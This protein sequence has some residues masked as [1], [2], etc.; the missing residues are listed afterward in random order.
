MAP[1][2]IT[3]KRAGSKSNIHKTRPTIS[4]IITIVHVHAPKLVS[5]NVANF[6][7][8][9]QEMTGNV[10]SSSTGCIHH[11]STESDFSSKSTTAQNQIE[12]AQSSCAKP[13]NGSPATTAESQD[14]P[15]MSGTSRCQ[16]ARPMQLHPA[17][18]S[19]ARVKEVK[20]EDEKGNVGG[21]L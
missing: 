8:L 2:G 14:R 15:C 4:P 11:E 3:A 5:T 9:V 10:S 20:R 12:I 13:M 21:T 6:R 16:Q 1:A 19:S 7:A 17:T 18:S